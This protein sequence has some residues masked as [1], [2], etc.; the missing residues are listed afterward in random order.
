MQISAKANWGPCP[1]NISTEPNF[2]FT[3][4]M[5]DWYEILKSNSV[6]YL[7]KGTCGIDHNIKLSEN[8]ANVYWTEIY[9]EEIREINQ[10]LTCEANSGQ[11][12][13]KFSKFLPSGDYKVI[14]TDYLNYA[15]V[16]S[17][18]NFWFFHWEMLWVLGREKQFNEEAEENVKGILKKIGFGSED[19]VMEDL[20]SCNLYEE[21]RSQIGDDL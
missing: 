16:Y 3:R 19:L 8:T 20:S 6:L 7:E 18:I 17:C 11:C 21:R 12:Y 1:S 9:N 5:G 4:Y 2:N 13:A 10:T 15:I 14:S